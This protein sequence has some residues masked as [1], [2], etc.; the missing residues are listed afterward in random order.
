VV[1][2]S[3]GGKIRFLAVVKRSQAAHPRAL[4]RSLRRLGFR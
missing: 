2:G 3:R 1:Y 4:K